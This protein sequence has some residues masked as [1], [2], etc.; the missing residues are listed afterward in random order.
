MVDPATQACDEE[1][2]VS[3]ERREKANNPVPPPWRST[4][5]GQRAN[6]PVPP[7]PKPAAKK[8]K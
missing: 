4:D 1:R 6:N 8:S 5:D 2:Q 7:P 3:D